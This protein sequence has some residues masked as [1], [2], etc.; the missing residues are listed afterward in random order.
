MT[1]IKRLYNSKID[2]NNE[3]IKNIQINLY[4]PKKNVSKAKEYDCLS[5]HNDDTCLYKNYIGA[6]N[7]D[8]KVLLI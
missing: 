1:S 7:A 2:N 3:K 5:L 8:N 4:R 6:W